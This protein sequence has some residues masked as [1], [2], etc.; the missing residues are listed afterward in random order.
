M[1][2][3]KEGHPIGEELPDREEEQLH[4]ADRQKE[5]FVI[6]VA[7]RLPMTASDAQQGMPSVKSVANEDTIREFASQPK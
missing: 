2:Q 4:V 7:T 3:S 1:E 5:Q 6:D